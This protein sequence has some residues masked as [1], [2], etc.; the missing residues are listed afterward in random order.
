M[1]RRTKSK[2]PQ[3]QKAGPKGRQLEVRAQQA[4]RLLV[5]YFLGTRNNDRFYAPAFRISAKG[6]L[7]EWK[8]RPLE[9]GGG[10][11]EAKEEIISRS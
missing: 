4:P 9:L 3:G 7:P 10:S 11:Q 6:E 2:M 1:A 5:I 8:I